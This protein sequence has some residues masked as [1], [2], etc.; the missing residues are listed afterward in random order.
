MNGILGQ[1]FGNQRGV[2]SSWDDWEQEHFPTLVRPPST[3]AYRVR[4]APALGAPQPAAP[5]AA[6]PQPQMPEIDHRR[7]NPLFL[8]AYRTSPSVAIQNLAPA[9]E[10]NAQMRQM[11]VD[12]MLLGRPDENDYSPMMGAMSGA[13]SG[14]ASTGN[15]LGALGGALVGYAKEKQDHQDA[16]EK[17]QRD[18]VEM[19]YRALT[20]Q[21]DFALQSGKAQIEAQQGQERLDLDRQQFQRGLIKDTNDLYTMDRGFS[22]EQQKEARRARIEEEELGMKRQDRRTAATERSN[23]GSGM[24]NPYL[25]WN[26]LSQGSTELMK[27]AK[28]NQSDMYQA[29]RKE[30]ADKLANTDKLRTELSNVVR[31][32]NPGDENGNGQGEAYKRLGDSK[33]DTY[34]AG[35]GASVTKNDPVNSINSSLAALSQLGRE[36]G[37]GQWTDKDA[38]L[39]RE[40]AGGAGA[41]RVMFA[42]AKEALDNLND[43]EQSKRDLDD[44]H[45]MTGG[46]ATGFDTFRDDLKS[47]RSQLPEGTK[48]DAKKY[49]EARAGLPSDAQNLRPF[50]D[51]DGKADPNLMIYDDPN[52]EDDPITFFKFRWGR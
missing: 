52:R 5:Q 23:L 6:V 7:V 46:G 40:A 48:V 44:Y 25:D 15:A 3:P 8:E 20:D 49:M 13:M 2:L 26:N 9:L 1:Q 14:V 45:Q 18:K 29:I 24:R 11:F 37:S 16:L 51:A 38:D 30:Y 50:V 19:I 33:I 21:R 43:L 39:A 27:E 28:K 31:L 36:K 47:F 32:L 17:Y 12:R 41:R 34:L 22:F 10:A 42:R 35:L 4:P